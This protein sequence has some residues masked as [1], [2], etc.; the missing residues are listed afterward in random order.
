[1]AGLLGSMI[2]GGVKS[3]ADG[4]VKD[5]EEKEEFDLKNALLE[6]Q[7]DKELRLKDAG[8]KMEDDREQATMDK[9]KGYMTGDDGQEL[10]AQEA[11]AKAMKAGDFEAGEGLLKMAP[12]T[13]K[14]FE[15]VKLDNGS[16][17]SFDKTN[18]TSK[19]IFEGGKEV[20]VPKDETE[21]IW[22]AANG[23]PEAKKA[24]DML[25]KQK[26]R[27]AN[28]GRAPERASDDDLAYSDWKKK[29][30]NRNKGRDDY[31]KEKSTWGKDNED[32]QTVTEAPVLDFNGTTRL[33]KNGNPMMT[34]KVTRK[35]KVSK[36][37]PAKVRTYNPAT[38]SFN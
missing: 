9:R 23:D 26:E 29:P 4:R 35:E 10:T 36:E 1:M 37:A 32:Y 24:A 5:I 18:G 6:A 25:V 16:V 20:K 38:K 8:Y 27:I 7:M 3:F 14:S 15:S 13:E 11:S 12:K 28:A 2:A 34:K 33:D 31:A 17:M 21:I 22:R 19:I 30:A